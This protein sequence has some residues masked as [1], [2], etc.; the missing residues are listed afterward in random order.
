M[1][2]IFAWGGATVFGGVLRLRDWGVFF[3][4]LAA[5]SLLASLFRLSASFFRTSASFFRISSMRA[6]ASSLR[7]SF[8]LFLISSSFFFISASLLHF[9]SFCFCASASFTLFSASFLRTSASVFLFTS[10]SLILR[11]RS[12]SPFFI[13]SVFFLSY[14][15]EMNVEISMDVS[16]CQRPRFFP[17]GRTKYSKF[18][19]IG[20]V[21]HR[22]VGGI[23][24]CFEFAF[25]VAT[26]EQDMID[27]KRQA[28]T[29]FKRPHD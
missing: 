5:A 17:L 4:G 12:N 1:D 23:D 14:L 10:S 21:W 11:F 24:A 9:S 27:C 28:W 15:Y 22:I 3:A 19:D 13:R 20:S 6:S 26:V 8:S 25:R 16:D 18:P 7:I 29:K 2:D